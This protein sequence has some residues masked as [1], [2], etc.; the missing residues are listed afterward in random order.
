MGFRPIT[1]RLRVPR[2]AS[3]P[4][5]RAARVAYPARVPVAL[6]TRIANV[7]GRTGVRL[8]SVQGAA[9]VLSPRAL[10][11]R[12]APV[13]RRAGVGTRSAIPRVAFR[14]PVAAADVVRATVRGGNTLVR[15]AYV[16][17][18]A[19]VCGCLAGV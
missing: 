8:A 11:S 6:V 1:T 15:G 4:G 12:H 7:P 17:H 14:T 5:R 16:A 13:R 19:S 18:A 2:K 3:I 9:R 10:V